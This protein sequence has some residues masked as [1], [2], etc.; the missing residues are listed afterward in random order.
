[1]RFV[2]AIAHDWSDAIGSCPQCANRR[3]KKKDA[4][5]VSLTYYGPD[6][7]LVEVV[8]EPTSLALA[9]AGGV[10]LMSRRRRSTV[11]GV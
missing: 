5:G 2:A 6:Y 4:V 1:V 8:P 10:V 3:E 9:V 11:A 7:G